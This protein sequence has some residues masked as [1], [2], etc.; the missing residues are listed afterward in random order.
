MFF[1]INKRKQRE[2]EE[3]LEKSRTS[4]LKGNERERERDIKRE[5]SSLTTKR[6]PSLR[7][8]ENYYFTII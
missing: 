6:K 2:R 8:G 3:K 4:K 5:I 7:K 1:S